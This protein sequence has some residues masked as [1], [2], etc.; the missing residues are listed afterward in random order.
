MNV[1]KELK[2]MVCVADELAT[3][4]CECSVYNIADDD[5]TAPYIRDRLTD[6]ADRLDEIE[7]ALVD[8]KGKH[9]VHEGPHY[10]LN[11]PFAERVCNTILAMLRG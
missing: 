11:C 7:K 8:I 6:I 10:Y 5:F 9:F 2:K 3:Q 4:P 1:I